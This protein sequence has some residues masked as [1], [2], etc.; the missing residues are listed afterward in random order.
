MI[1]NAANEGE[2]A[3]YTPADR[4][5][6]KELFQ[7]IEKVMNPGSSLQ[8]GPD[9]LDLL[10]SL[11]D[12]KSVDFQPTVFVTWDHEPKEFKTE[13][14]LRASVLR[15]YLA[16]AETVVRHETEVVFLTH[17]LLYF[18]TTVP[19][20]I[21]LYYD[22]H[23]LHG[24]I[25]VLVTVWF[26]GSFTLMMHNHIHN[27]GILSRSWGAFDFFFPYVLEPLMGHTWDSYYYH[28]VKHHH[29]EGNGPDDLS[30]TIRY[31][32]DSI[33]AFLHYEYRFIVFGWCELPLY[34]AKKGKYGLATRTFPL[35]ILLLALHISDGIV[36][37]Q[38]HLVCVYPAFVHLEGGLDDRKFG[39]SMHWSMEVDPSSDFRSS[40]TLI[41]PPVRHPIPHVLRHRTNVNLTE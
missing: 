34:F 6:L 17:I 41:D 21:Y 4:I 1:S 22:F 40:I 15:L 5:V 20:A 37:V 9:A 36:E 28:H 23:Y 3:A 13:V 25:H 24:L 8:R 32:R 30:S 26:S 33:W 10:T 16:W 7:D 29:V 38:A 14:G 11:N 31:Q 35:G 12:R 18:S 19:S 27:N 2:D 39:A